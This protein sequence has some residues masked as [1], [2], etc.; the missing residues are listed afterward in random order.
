MVHDPSRIRGSVDVAALN[1]DG[2]A[3]LAEGRNMASH[4]RVM[5]EE[6]AVMVERHNLQGQTAAELSWAAQLMI[7]VGNS[8]A[9]NG[10]EMINYAE[11]LRRSL[12]YS[13]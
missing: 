2:E 10:Q 4:G 6:T 5:A 8:L 11:Q 12:G 1:S 13:N 7:D 9:W 3:M